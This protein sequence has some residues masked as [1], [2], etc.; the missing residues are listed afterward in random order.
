MVI[1][2]VVDYLCV[3]KEL[4]GHCHVVTVTCS[5]GTIKLLVYAG[6]GVCWYINCFD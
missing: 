1:L 3:N 2:L 6:P 5:V 4:M